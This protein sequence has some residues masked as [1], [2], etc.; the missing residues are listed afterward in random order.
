MKIKMK[1]NIN[2]YV[3]QKFAGPAQ[4]LQ[5]GK[6]ALNH[7]RSAAPVNKVLDQETRRR[8]HRGKPEEAD[9]SR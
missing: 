9:R 5:P 2:K 4:L 1:I 6:A 8:D 7:R 3:G